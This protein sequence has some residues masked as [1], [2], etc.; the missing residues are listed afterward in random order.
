[1]GVRPLSQPHSEDNNLPLL[2]AQGAQGEEAFGSGF[3]P[4]SRMMRL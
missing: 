4:P 1:M 3:A 2:A